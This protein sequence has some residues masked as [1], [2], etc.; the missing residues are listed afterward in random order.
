MGK[1]CLMKF[2]TENIQDETDWIKAV[3]HDPRS[4]LSEI[5]IGS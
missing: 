3:I 1:F 2:V 5:Y 4:I